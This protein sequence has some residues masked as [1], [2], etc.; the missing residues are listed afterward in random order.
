MKSYPS[1]PDNKDFL[2]KEGYVYIKYDG[3]NIRAEWSKKRGW[4]KFGTRKN[5][6]D[7]SNPIYGSIIPLF[8]EKYSSELEKVF[9][10]VDPFKSMEK[11]VCFF[12]WFGENS[13]AGH[14]DQDDEKNLI[15]F[16]INIHKKGFLS[17]EKFEET[18]EHLD[19][20][21]CLGKFTISEL[22]VDHIRESRIDLNS[23]Y[24]IRNKIPE[25]VIAKNGEG[26][27]R[28]ACK[29]KTYDYLEKLKEHYND[30]W[31]SFWE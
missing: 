28:W 1:I 20:A 23:K 13:F 24:P 5:V 4:H 7:S 6:F 21:E 30:D 19:I 9:K 29:I 27:K 15:L 14:H 25:G 17:P 10:F 8:K 12:E 26:H 11:C 18:F 3:S 31:T 2:E 16:D 22:F